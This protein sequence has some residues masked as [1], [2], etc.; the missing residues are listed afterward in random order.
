MPFSR[1]SD[2]L[3]GRMTGE[4]FRLMQLCLEHLPLGEHLPA[5]IERIGKAQINVLAIAGKNVMVRDHRKVLKKL[6]DALRLCTILEKADLEV[7]TDILMCR[8][9][10]DQEAKEKELERYLARYVT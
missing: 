2:E 8:W 1:P 7:E 3:A 4:F 5:F 9:R 6:S 10:S